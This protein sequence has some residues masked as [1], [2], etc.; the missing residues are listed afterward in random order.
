MEMKKLKNDQQEGI[1]AEDSIGIRSK[2]D[3]TS[4][5]GASARK[6]GNYAN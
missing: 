5:P 3:V 6:T 4:D 1:S 2:E